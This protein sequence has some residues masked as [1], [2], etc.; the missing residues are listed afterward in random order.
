MYVGEN[1]VL[2]EADYFQYSFEE[3]RTNEKYVDGSWIYTKTI[4]VQNPTS[5]AQSVAH[6][7]SNLARVTKF[8]GSFSRGDGVPQTIPCYY[9][10]W[11]VFVYDFR[12]ADF[13]VRISSN[14]YNVGISNFYITLYYTKTTD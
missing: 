5:G 11:E 7:I 14:Q 1:K 13:V 3:Q 6:N 12:S 10:N 4:E 9:T 2:T 8:E